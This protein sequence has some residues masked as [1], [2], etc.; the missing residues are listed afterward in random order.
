MSERTGAR[1]ASAAIVMSVVRTSREN[2]LALLRGRLRYD[3]RGCACDERR[4]VWVGG[5]P[6]VGAR[7]GRALRATVR[8]SE[9]LSTTIPS[10]SQR[11]HIVRVSGNVW[12]GSWA[13]LPY[14]PVI[15]PTPRVTASAL[16]T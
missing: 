11:G 2:I 14:R 7:W 16:W 5:N 3:G 10:V 9:T 6:A 4:A 1:H 12:Q 15:E 13:R 8:P